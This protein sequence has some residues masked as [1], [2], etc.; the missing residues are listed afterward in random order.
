MRRWSPR[1][2][3]EDGSVS[4]ELVI[5][6][7]V[8][9]LLI[10]VVVQ[11]ALWEHAAH[12]AQAGAQEGLAAGRVEGGNQGTA[13]DQARTVL[14]HLG[15]TVLVASTVSASRTNATTTVVVTGSAEGI[16]PFLHLPVHAVATGPTEQWSPG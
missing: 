5:A 16:L 12:I 4:L 6:T 7:P 2:R 15:S 1:W 11:F 13:V 8:L 10:L 3:D 9:L 14:A